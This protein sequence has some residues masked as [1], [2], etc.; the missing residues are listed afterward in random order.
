MCSFI[1]AIN[2][3][4]WQ[5]FETFIFARHICSPMFKI[6]I[7]CPRVK[8]IHCPSKR[9]STPVSFLA[10]FVLILFFFDHFRWRIVEQ[11]NV[12]LREAFRRY[13]VIFRAFYSK[14]FL[15]WYIPFALKAR[16][17]KQQQFKPLSQIFRAKLSQKPFAKLRCILRTSSSPY[18]AGA[19]VI[20]F[21][22]ISYF[23]FWQPFWSARI[24]N[25]KTVFILL[26]NVDFT[27][28]LSP[29]QS[30]F[31]L[32]DLLTNWAVFNMNFCNSIVLQLVCL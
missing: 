21:L 28:T 3:R 10:L 26:Y 17:D 27:T 23:D 2:V 31:H 14:V 24:N 12:F 8:L 13:A 7:L 9:S 1:S 11:S 5:N 25:F 19:L 30:S 22:V 20:K 32:N 6:L 15:Y 16:L 18:F 4:I 29:L